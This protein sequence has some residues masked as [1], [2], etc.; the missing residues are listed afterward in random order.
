MSFAIERYLKDFGAPQPSQ[1]A[2]SDFSEESFDSDT[3]SDFPG[4]MPAPAVDAE[5][6]QTQAYAE[7]Y[8]AAAAELAARHEEALQ[9][10][11]EQHA[12]DLER[13][14]Q[15]YQTELAAR[16]VAGLRQIAAELAARIS[17]ELADCLAPVLQSEIAEKAVADMAVLIQEA[18]LEG[19]AGPIIV[20]GPLPLFNILATEMREDAG[21][22]R[23]VEADDLDLSVE[24]SGS[25]LVTRLSAFAASLKKVLE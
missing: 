6:I 12:Q 2:F 17:D 21:L 8:E 5:A 13:V 4:M 20:K 3:S 9:Q 23:H 19:E 1:P 11:R 14:E 24:I 7:G 18:I 15:N 22:L 16:V 10:L 25:V